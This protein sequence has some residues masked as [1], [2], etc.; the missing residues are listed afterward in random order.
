MTETAIAEHKKN[1]EI[2]HSER[3]DQY[4]MNIQVVDTPR[5]ETRIV[6]VSSGD[7]AKEIPDFEGKT[8]ETTVRYDGETTYIY[9]GIGDPD[10]CT[11]EHIRSAAAC[12]VRKAGLLKRSEV[13][14]VEP[15]QLS[16]DG[17]PQAALEGAIL[18]AYRYA[19]FKTEKPVTVD[20]IDYVGNHLTDKDAM[21]NGV[22]CESVNFARDLVNE[23]ASD[24]YPDRL[25]R[26]ARMMAEQHSMSC[27]ILTEKEISERGLGLL[28]AVGKGS[29]YPPRLIILEYKGAPDTPH[30]TAVVGKGITFDSGGQNLKPRGGI[31]TMRTDMAGAATTLGIMRVIG[32]L[33]PQINVIGVVAAAHNAIGGDAYFPGDVYRSYKGTTVEITNTDAEGRLVLADAFSYVQT[34]FSPTEMIDF[35]TLTGGILVALGSTVTGLFSNDDAMAQKLFDSGE[36]TGERLWRLPL[37]PEYTD[38]MKSDIADLRNSAKLKKGHAS[39][40]TAGA[41][42]REFVEEDVSWCHLDIAGTAFNEGEPRGINPK[43]ATGVGIRLI[44]NY[45]NLN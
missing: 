36:E 26:E 34:H 33:K 31:E 8:G 41:F 23:N 3:G 10:G 16:N 13:T 27:T 28:E 14:V 12:G 9:C 17:G 38:A 32:T 20:R 29:P 18:G 7:T 6:F 45:L 42:L 40:V 15:T 44:M 22:I 19:H 1:W 24:V 4:Q 43:L 25:A 21:R 30:K 39:S 5:N 35:A 11:T 2:K 37:Y